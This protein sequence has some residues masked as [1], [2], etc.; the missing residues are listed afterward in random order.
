MRE[1]WRSAEE[2]LIWETAIS[3]GKV[4]CY[5]RQADLDAEKL[6]LYP[7]LI[8]RRYEGDHLVE[9]AILKIVMRCYYADTFEQLVIQ[10][11][12]EI[13]NRWGGYAGEFYGE[14]LELILQFR[15]GD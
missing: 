9:E 12:F 5:S 8:Y 3:G 7:E 15:V 6:I 10:N 11:G 13:I 14:G 4:I 2:Y 1:K